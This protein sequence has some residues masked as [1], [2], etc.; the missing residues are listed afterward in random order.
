[1]NF[2][3]N[4]RRDK[5]EQD[6]SQAAARKVFMKTY[7]NFLVIFLLVMILMGCANL[8]PS[9]KVTVKSPWQDYNS[10]KLDYEKITPGLTTVEELNKLG[11]TPYQVP[12]IRILNATEVI[13]I[14]MPTPAIRIENLDRGIQKCIE[15]KDQCVA[16]RIEPSLLESK[17]IGNFW[18]D[19]LSFK[20]D[21]VS[22]GWEFRGLITI[23]DNV[24]TY[25]DPAGGRPSISTEDIQ[26]KPLGPLQDIGGVIQG[27]TPSLLR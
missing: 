5:A 25:K 23:V 9:G 20:R 3:C 1:L 6:S 27:M 12:N 2:F 26:K 17:R 19:L 8:L 11:F 22:T 14:F 24:V 21:T 10:A 16:Y 15:S 13:T 7:P 18:L 4:G